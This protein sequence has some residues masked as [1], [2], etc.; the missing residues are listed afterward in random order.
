MNMIEITQKVENLSCFCAVCGIETIH[1][2]LDVSEQRFNEYD[3]DLYGADYVYSCC[4][5]YYLEHADFFKKD[6]FLQNAL[7]NPSFIENQ[8]KL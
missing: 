2:P 4:R 8:F 1:S 3:E 5:C 6:V 7:E